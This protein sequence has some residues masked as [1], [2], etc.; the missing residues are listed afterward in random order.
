MRIYAIDH[1]QVAMPVGGEDMAR[2]FYCGVLLLVEKAKPSS[3]AGRGGVW[4]E[5]DNVRVHVGVDPNFHPQTKAHLGLLV[6]DLQ[7]F[8]GLCEAAGYPTS[9]AEPIDGYSRAYVHDPFGNRVELMQVT[10]GRTEP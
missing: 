3:L 9:T 10:D 2:Q 5:D 8:I 4:F 6:D 1:I 7:G